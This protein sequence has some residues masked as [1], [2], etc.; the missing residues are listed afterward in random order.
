M[1]YNQK[2]NLIIAGV[3][4]LAGILA[5]GRFIITKNQNPQPTNYYQISSVLDGDTIKIEDG[6]RVRLIGIDAPESGAC[7]YNESTQ[8]LKDLVENKTVR[9]EKDMTDKDMYGRL[10]RYVILPNENGDDL[11][12]NDDLVRQGF[13]K[14]LAMP[15]DTRYRDLLASA[16]Q[17]AYKSKLGMWGKCGYE[18]ENQANRE[19]DSQPMDPACVIKGNISEKGYGKTYLIPGC[20]SYDSAKVDP[21]KGE[22]YFCT[23]EEAVAAG[24][25]Q[26]ANCP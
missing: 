24:F 17:A 12:V 19:L 7:Y 13:A 21:R 4:F 3:I 1:K 10:L 8:T 20:A 9:L 11:L 14:T 15:P 18:L 16:Q 2:R 22:Q 25:R 26:A 23:A 6:Q 5:G